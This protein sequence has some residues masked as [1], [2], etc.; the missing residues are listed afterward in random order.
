M[1]LFFSNFFLY[2]QG[3]G[4]RDANWV[5]P[6][7]SSAADGASVNTD[8]KAVLAPP[9]DKNPHV[10]SRSASSVKDCRA[11][12]V[13]RGD[14]AEVKDGGEVEGGAVPSLA[15]PAQRSTGLAKDFTDRGLGAYTSVKRKRDADPEDEKENVRRPPPRGTVQE[16]PCCG[17]GTDLL[18][19]WDVDDFDVDDFD[20]DR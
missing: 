5:V 10:F 11:A 15:V 20:V 16:G 14:T 9:P 7:S 6:T 4:I 8:D 1:Q 13:K 17:E 2:P 3:H 18:D 19:D 12:E